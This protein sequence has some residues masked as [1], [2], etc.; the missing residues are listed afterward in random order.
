M[1]KCLGRRGDIFKFCVN[2][3]KQRKIFVVLKKELIA[4]DRKLLSQAKVSIYP[5]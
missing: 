4:S 3:E 2:S 5:K 1:N